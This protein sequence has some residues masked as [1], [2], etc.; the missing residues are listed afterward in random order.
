VGS[1]STPRLL[2]TV[3]LLALVPA[4]FEMPALLT[5]AAVTVGLCALVAYE[6]VRF[7]TVRDQVRHQVPAD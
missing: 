2:A 3:G 5:L 6:T 1:V 7:A 4:A